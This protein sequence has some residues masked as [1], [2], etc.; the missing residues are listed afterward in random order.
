M[1]QFLKCEGGW[2]VYILCLLLSV[3]VQFRMSGVNHLGRWCDRCLTLGINLCI[4]VKIEC[5]MT[6]HT[7]TT[8]LD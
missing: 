8:S 3:R 2:D 7:S 5:L 1:L 4:A 6:D